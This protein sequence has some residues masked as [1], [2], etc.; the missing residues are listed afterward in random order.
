M[1]AL[2]GASAAVLMLYDLTKPVE[3]PLSIDA[4]RLLFKEGGKKGLWV[5]RSGMS[6]DERTH[7]RPQSDP[8]LDGESVAVITL[9]DRAAAGVYDDKSGALLEQRLLAMGP[10]LHRQ[11]LAAGVVSLA[12]S[13]KAVAPGMDILGPLL[14][15]ALAMIRG[16]PHA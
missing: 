16:R 3:P 7:S 15:H 5:H 6:A 11:L 12:G 4:L 8:R 1:E 13:P 14:P 2:T 10:N 9:S